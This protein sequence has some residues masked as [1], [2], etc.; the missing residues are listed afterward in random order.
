MKSTMNGQVLPSTALALQAHDPI[1]PPI[2]RAEHLRPRLQRIMAL[3]LQHADLICDGTVGSLE[4]H[5]H[6]EALK[7]K[8]VHHLE[9]QG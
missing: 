2:I 9:A 7:A 8:L 3:L 4:L 5:F 6:G 1:V